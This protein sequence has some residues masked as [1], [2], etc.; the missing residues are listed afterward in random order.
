MSQRK[1][2]PVV[3]CITE[4]S[5]ALPYKRRGISPDDRKWA[6][7]LRDD[8]P[9]EN[10][11]PFSD[12]NAGHYQHAREYADIVFDNYLSGFRSEIGIIDVMTH[13]V[14]LSIMCY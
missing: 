14:N 6:H 5:R 13:S 2:V 3:D 9:G 12:S 11:G 7:V 4:I 10:D 8:R 1:P